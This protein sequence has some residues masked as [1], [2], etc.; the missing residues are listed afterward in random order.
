MKDTV[1]RVLNLSKMYRINPPR[2]TAET[3]PEAI[4]Q[5]LTSPFSWLRTMVKAPTEEEQVW[6]LRDVG[7]DVRRGEVVAVLGHNGAGKS[8]LLKILAQLTNPSSGR[9]EIKGRVA[10]LM[11]TGTGFHP[12]LT[13]RENVYINGA[14]LG[15]TRR[16]VATK[17]DDILAFSEIDRFIDT[18]IKRYSKGMVSRLGFA[19][20]I[21]FFAETVILDEVLAAGDR[22]FR[23][24]C[25]ARISEESSKGR[26]ILIA[27]HM[28]GQLA[29]FCS[30]AILLS[31]G[32]L[33]YDGDVETAVEL[34]NHPD[35]GGPPPDSR[36]EAMRPGKAPEPAET[37]VMAAGLHPGAPLAA[38]PI[39]TIPAPRPQSDL[40]LDRIA[41]RRLEIETYDPRGQARGALSYD[42]VDGGPADGSA[43]SEDEYKFLLSILDG[44][45]KAFF[46]D[47][48]GLLHARS[49][50][51]LNLLRKEPPRKLDPESAGISCRFLKDLLTDPHA[52]RVFCDHLRED[53]FALTPDLIG[54]LNE[55]LRNTLGGF[56]LAP[57]YYGA[58]WIEQPDHRTLPAFGPLAGEVISAKKTFLRHDRLFTIFGALSSLKA[59]F[60]G[61]PLNLAEAGV[62]RGGVTRF[63][64]TASEALGLRSTVF[65]FDA[66][67]G[68]LPEDVDVPRDGP[69]RLN[70]AF[71]KTDL[72]SV[73]EYLADRKDV[74]LVVGRVQD[75]LEK[76][77]F[78]EVHLVHLD[79][80]LYRPTLFCL[81][82]FSRL[83]SP[84][85]LLLVDDHN[86]TKTPGVKAAVE[87]FLS[88][89][90]EYAPLPLLTG[91]CLLVKLGTRRHPGTGNPADGGPTRGP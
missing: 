3:V 87:E 52:R 75:T 35:G 30:R 68:Y 12:E 39:A 45:D 19:V 26:T 9:I 2:R 4:R 49:P 69:E 29:Q 60:P 90:P 83:Q 37:A 80:D 54:H 7:F 84:G 10:A 48:W 31:H 8:T 82:R 65:G 1:I 44:R 18:P 78:E 51:F 16:E 66:F 40:G 64:S 11:A 14:L 21:H 71:R 57:D 27:S 28:V 22:V 81:E 53:G 6:A 61:Q 76:P 23:T 41:I 88:R 42:A 73:R 58:S 63:L 74:R 67:E 59:S 47:A 24:K 33:V 85:C 89:S 86:F 13:G 43:G 17:F 15:L 55:V 20:A 36:K 70:G 50:A 25:L 34:Y 46:V 56:G 79:L 62:F 72:A 5:F 91:Q 77:P 32:R 38:Q